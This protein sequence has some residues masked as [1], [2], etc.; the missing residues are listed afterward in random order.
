MK[1][2]EALEYIEKLAKSGMKPGLERMRELC[3]R[4]GDPQESLRMVHIAGTN[5]KGSVLAFMSSILQMA[6]YRVGCYI[7]PAVFDYREKI[8]INGKGIGKTSVGEGM[9]I[10]RDISRAMIEDGLEPPTVFEIETALA[11]WYFQKKKCKIVFLET[12]MGG[13]EDATNVIHHN[14]MAVITTISRDHMKYLGE[15]LTE[16]AYQKAGI[17][18]PGCSVVIGKQKQEVAEVLINCANKN[19][20]NLYSAEDIKIS[21]VHYTLTKT[22][23][24]TEVMKNMEISI[25]GKVQIDNAVLAL[26]SIQVLSSKGWKIPEEAVR[27]GFQEAKWMGRFT[28]VGHRPLFVVDGAHNEDAAVRLAESLEFYFTNRRIVFIIGM[29]KDKETE[30]VLG[31]TSKYAEQIITITPPNNARALTAYELAKQAST[32]HTQVTAA[33][34]IEEAVEMSYLLA[35][36]E[37][38]IVAFGS[39]SYLGKVIEILENRAYGKAASVKNG[40][41]RE[42]KRRH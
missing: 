8:T 23:F 17:M 31:I 14:E 42:N 40:Q 12:G 21:K 29:L 24:D 3:H 19:T 37:D 4:M 7:S 13:K 30:K 16:I 26:K 5:G 25:L 2:Q 1:Y 11:F 20:C 34:S 32:Y 6:G 18:K 22:K 38:V 9:E 35:D 39:L 41:P 27:K 28:I 10:L 36:R 15:S 33:D